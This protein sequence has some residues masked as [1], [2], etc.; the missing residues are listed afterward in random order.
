M[1]SDRNARNTLACVDDHQ[2]RWSVSEAQ[3]AIYQQNFDIDSTAME[4]LL[5]PQSLVPNSVRNY[6]GI[7]EAFSAYLVLLQN[8]FSDRLSRFGFNHFP[9]FLV[10]LMHEVELGTW[11]SLFIHLLRILDAGGESLLR[12]LD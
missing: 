7:V 8:A 5:K 11:K 6:G 1:K 10:D 2:R 3:K 4:S 9:L 12:E